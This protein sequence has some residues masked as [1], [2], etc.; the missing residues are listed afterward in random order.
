MG[1]ICAAARIDPHAIPR[2][3]HHEAIAVV[4]DLVNPVGSSWRTRRGCWEARFNESGQYFRFRGVRVPHHSAN[5]R[6]LPVSTESSC[7]S[8]GKVAPRFFSSA[9]PAAGPRRS[10]RFTDVQLS[11][12]C[13]SQ[14][15]SC[16][17]LRQLGHSNTLRPTSADLAVNDLNAMST[18][19]RQGG[20]SIESG[21][22][23]RSI[24]CSRLCMCIGPRWP[25]WLVA[26][27]HVP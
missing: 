25:P 20:T 2:P 23:R 17:S 21:I 8:D 11:D 4:L 16:I 15:I 18:P 22:R 19:H 7:G 3:A 13:G 24:I 27:G 1:P 6:R 10:T 9:S 12:C 26:S 14:I 5:L